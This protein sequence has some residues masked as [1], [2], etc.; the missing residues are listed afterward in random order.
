MSNLTPKEETQLNNFAEHKS[1]L[2]NEI[3]TSS[4]ELHSIRTLI[5]AAREDLSA[6]EKQ[7][8]AARELYATIMKQTDEK[9]KECDEKLKKIAGLTKDLARG[10]KDFEKYRDT[11]LSRIASEKARAE[12]AV[13]NSNAELEEIK[14]RIGVA[15]SELAKETTELATIREALSEAYEVEREISNIITDLQAEKVTLEHEVKEE[16]TALEY[17]E[18]LVKEEVE[19]ITLPRQA[20]AMDAATIVR[21][22]RN[23]N[24]MIGRLQRV[25]AQ[26]YPGRVLKI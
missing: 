19:K 24:V 5:D 23:L 10:I 2:L 22:E 8:E 15:K 18:E 7:I 14:A 9:N 13:T 12:A 4:E 3:Q 1:K 25:Y 11:E 17:A 6:I 26:L 16:Q 20:L 21:R